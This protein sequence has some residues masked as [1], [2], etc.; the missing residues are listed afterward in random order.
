MLD[1]AKTKSTG[2]YDCAFEQHLID[3]NIFPDGFEYTDGRMPP[4]PENIDEIRRALGQR[5]AS[6]SSSQFSGEDFRK[7]RSAATKATKETLVIGT[8]MPIIEGDRRD[9]NCVS[10]DVVFKN[11][12]PLTD[13]SLSCVKPDIVYG[14]PLHQL[15]R[16]VR[17]ELSK[18]II[19]STQVDQPVAPNNFVEVKGPCGSV[20]V[21]TRQALYAATF[22]ARGLQSLQSYGTA[23]PRYDDKAYT[24]AWTYHLGHLKAYAHHPIPPSTP[25]A[26]PGYVMT[27]VK[28]WSLT[29]DVESF[30]LGAAAYRNGRDWAKSQR[31]QAIAQANNKAAS[32]ERPLCSET[33]AASLARE[34]LRGGTVAAF[35]QGTSKDP[36]LS[37]HHNLDTSEDELA[38][39][40]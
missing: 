32:I 19:P 24:L 36:S 27:Q 3:H 39:D 15:H 34:R 2:P 10:D 23:E 30:R 25:G 20:P 33:N 13:G 1:T 9:G 14:A 22:G 40:L 6:L 16:K 7:F 21:A 8:V 31:D 38:L 17:Q 11:L 29:S 35:S 12:H 26:Q 18:L 5:R 4:E 28:S 37:L